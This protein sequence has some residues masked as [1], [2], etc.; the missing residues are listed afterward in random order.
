MGT[1]RRDWQQTGGWRYLRAWED[2][3]LNQELLVPVRQHPTL[4]TLP[5]LF[6][7]VPGKA[8]NLRG[9]FSVYRS[10]VTCKSIWIGSSSSHPSNSASQPSIYIRVLIKL[11]ASYPFPSTGILLRA[12]QGGTTELW[13]S[14]LHAQPGSSSTALVQA[15]SQSCLVFISQTVSRSE[16]TCRAL[17]C[18][19]VLKAG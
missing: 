15:P 14:R 11:N 4:A 17:L 8:Q 19:K 18:G 1:T 6:A 7:K 2:S 13:R 3:S 12:L 5:T 10:K 9:A 16:L